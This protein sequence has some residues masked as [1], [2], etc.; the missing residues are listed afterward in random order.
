MHALCQAHFIAADLMSPRTTGLLGKLLEQPGL[1]SPNKTQNH[2]SSSANQ[3]GPSP[4]YGTR[5]FISV[6]TRAR[7]RSR[8]SALSTNLLTGSSH[9]CLSWSNWALYKERYAFYCVVWSQIDV[10]EKPVACISS[11]AVLALSP[12]Y[13]CFLFA[14]NSRPEKARDQLVGCYCSSLTSPTLSHWR[15]RLRYL[16]ECPSIS[17]LHCATRQK[18]LMFYGSYLCSL[19]ELHTLKMSGGVKA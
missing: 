5:Q 14:L 1:L 6:L 16:V 2:M 7:H 10:A 17:K 15:W 3:V 12:P 8:H 13:I 18:I 9:L 19:I 11:W 4:L